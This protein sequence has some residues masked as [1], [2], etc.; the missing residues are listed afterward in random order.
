[1]EKLTKNTYGPMAKK[2]KLEKIFFL[3]DILLLLNYRSS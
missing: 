1:M 3:K 2:K